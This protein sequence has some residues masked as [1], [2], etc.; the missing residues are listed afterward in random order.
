M[1]RP[2]SRILVV[3]DDP[4]IRELL[5]DRLQLMRLEVVCAGDGEE[6][7]ALLRQ[8]APPLT[9]LDLQLPR[10]SGMEVLHAIRRETIETTVIVITALGTPERAVEAMRA[11]AYDFIPKP[12]DPAHLEV[13]INKALER[14]SLREENRL[15]HGE[16]D[17]LDRPLIGDTPAIQDLVR[18]AQQA[19][20]SNATILLRGES[21]T[22]KEILARA[23]HRWS[24]R[25]DRPLVTVNCVALSEELLE[26]ELFGHEKGAFTGAHQRKQGKVELANGGTL[27][28]DEIGDIRPALQ[29]KLLRLIQEQEFE[30]VGGTR[31][32]RV[33]VR[34]VAA[35][36]TD[37]ERAM[38]EG[39]FR[40][41]LYYRLNVVTLVLPPLRE[42]KEDVES[43][44]RHFIEKYSAEL[45]R[46][47]KTISPA[48]L[49]MLTRYEWPGNVR[50]LE[51]AIERAVVLSVDA[52]IGPKDLPIL[53]G[54]PS[55]E[56]PEG[57]SG[58][59]HE[60]V[61]QFK[62]ELLRSALAQANGN[63]TRA[64][65]ALGLQRTYLSRLL[66]DLGIRES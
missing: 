44:A 20:A 10:V 37:L 57:A 13:V 27:F 32:I 47:T 33:D 6:A 64:A 18:T 1:T 25:R 29:A 9:L 42:R 7:L 12:L 59:Y 54:E 16:L 51:N 19:A 48:A 61:L 41:D 28:L 45:K 58:T 24:P 65:E 3:D 55:D 40:Q 15:L 14:D 34:F 30:R 26:S 5:S 11:G 62:R 39:R 35:T 17:S 43:L 66:K 56:A 21:G 8:E 4:D 23:I 22:G 36:N 52:E 60:A 2:R 49:A 50:E 38:K 31:P 53:R 63:Q 46:P